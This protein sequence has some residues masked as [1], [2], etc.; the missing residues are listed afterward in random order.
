MLRSRSN[1]HL[2]IGD[3]PNEPSK[4]IKY[5]MPEIINWMDSF[6]NLGIKWN[7]RKDIFKDR[8]IKSR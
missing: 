5:Q 2:T 6:I 3:S 4:K 1:S 8:G 7:K